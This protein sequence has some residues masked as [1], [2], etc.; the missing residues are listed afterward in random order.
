MTKSDAVLMF[1][2]LQRACVGLLCAGL[3]LFTFGCSG[4]AGSNPRGAAT[5]DNHSR[6][7]TDQTPR[8][9]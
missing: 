9:P 5:D 7:P 3:I 6:G 4:S 2:N 8:P 1:S